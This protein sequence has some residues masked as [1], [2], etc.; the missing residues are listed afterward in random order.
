MPLNEF[1]IEEAEAEVEEVTN[2]TE[3]DEDTEMDF[4]GVSDK[5]TF[6]VLPTG[7]YDAQVV[8]CEFEKS[9][10]G[11]P[12]LSWKFKIDDGQHKATV[13]FHTVLQGDALPRTKRTIM[14]IAPDADLSHFRPSDANELFTGRRCRLKIKPKKYEGELRNNVTD[15]L[16]AGD[17]GF[18][19]DA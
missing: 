18:F 17:G 4:S 13:F 6:A 9:R 16:T 7:T 8:S 2:G 5:T 10:A 14:R 12:M 1:G 11:N 15:V 3:L 19:G